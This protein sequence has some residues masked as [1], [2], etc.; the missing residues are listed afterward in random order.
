M[1]KNLK[2]LSFL[3]IILLNSAQGCLANA[4][5]AP[6]AQAIPVVAPSPILKFLFAM[7]GVLIS[8]IAIF[9]GLRIY[10][11]FVLKQGANS[12]NTNYSTLQSPKN[13]KEAINLFLDKTDK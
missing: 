8:A 4:A 13:L 1:K 7:L 11:K 3:F 12:D 10:Q 9:G 6:V 5:T 2:T